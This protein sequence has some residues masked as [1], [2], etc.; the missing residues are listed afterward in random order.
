MQTLGDT[1]ETNVFKAASLNTAHPGIF[2]LNSKKITL[3]T[4]LFNPMAN[5]LK[6][7]GQSIMND[8]VKFFLHWNLHLSKDHFINLTINWRNLTSF[9]TD[10]LSNS[11]WWFDDQQRKDFFLNLAQYPYPYKGFQWESP[12][13]ISGDERQAL[14]KKFSGDLER[15]LTPILFS[16]YLVEGRSL[17]AARENPELVFSNN[18]ENSH[19]TL[20]VGSS[21]EYI[22]ASEILL[23]CVST[24]PDSPNNSEFFADYQASDCRVEDYFR[25]P[26]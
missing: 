19:Y 10:R 22:G 17:Y 2:G 25:A 26:E 24:N 8:Q 9:L 15:W 1:S 4:D 6:P 21:T 11:L 3:Y 23:G 5:K 13:E 16:H 20:F 18:L 12:V 7:G 14:A